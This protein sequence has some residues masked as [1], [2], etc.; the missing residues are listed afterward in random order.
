MAEVS[1]IRR[2]S[3]RDLVRFEESS[4]VN[5]E[6]ELGHVVVVISDNKAHMMC[7]QG[8]SDAR[9]YSLGD[10]QVVDVLFQVE[11]SGREGRS[12]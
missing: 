10:V 7:P 5:V 12:E 9:K 4:I 11:D 2:C 8:I 3:R 6:I 1:D